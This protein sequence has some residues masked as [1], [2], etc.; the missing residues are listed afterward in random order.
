M[1]C[2]GL[3]WLVVELISW[4]VLCRASEGFR[5]R[6]LWVKTEGLIGLICVFIF[7]WCCFVCGRAII[8]L[9]FVVFAET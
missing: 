7:G 5:S 1:Y 6:L 8:G 3:S 9:Y 4:S 2:L